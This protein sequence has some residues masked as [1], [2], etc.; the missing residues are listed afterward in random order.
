MKEMESRTLAI[1]ALILPLTAISSG[2]ASAQG[3]GEIGFTFGKSSAQA[4]A[5]VGSSALS[6]A[7][8]LALQQSVR[9]GALAL[10]CEQK[11][12]LDEAAR[13]YKQC[14]N[15][16]ASILKGHDPQ[17]LK[18][19]TAIAKVMYRQGKLADAETFFRQ[20]LS[21]TALKYGPGSN[22]LNELMQQLG[23]ICQSEKKYQDAC[24]YLR[25]VLNITEKRVGPTDPSALASRARLAEVCME[26]GNLAEA[27]LVLKPSCNLSVPDKSRDQLLTVLDDYGKLMRQTG[28]TAQADQVEARARSIR[29]GKWPE[30][31]ALSSS[32]APEPAASEPAAPA[33]AAAQPPG[34]PGSSSR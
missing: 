24:Y 14:L 30:P 32:T 21:L 6:P 4:A 9:L 23:K 17:A 29:E 18:Y 20:A 33:A 5:T 28:C 34:S 13:L 26:G 19:V 1:F 31:S 22:E 3:L 2:A 12:N 25:Q 8:A 16:R 15:I 11:G 10:L 27:E 7:A